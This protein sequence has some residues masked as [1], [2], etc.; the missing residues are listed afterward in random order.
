MLGIS[1][2]NIELTSRCNKKCPMCGRRQL[3]KQ[4]PEYEQ[5]LGDMDFDLFQHIAAQIPA[6]TVVQLH[7][8]GEPTLYEKLYNATLFLR[9]R[10][11]YVCMDTNG[12]LIGELCRELVWFHSITVSVIQG[13]T[14]ENYDRQIHQLALCVASIFLND[15][16]TKIN[17]RA[18]GTIPIYFHT[19]AKRHGIDIIQRIFHAPEMSHSY[20]KKVTMPEIGVCLDLL[21]HPAIDRFGDV[22]PCVRFNPDNINNLGN[23]KN[24]R[25]VDILRD[26][27]RA[28]MIR[29]HFNG[30]RDE[31]PLCDQC[32][33][34]GVP[35]S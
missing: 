14:T 26:P 6:G 5:T 28:E 7:W 18:L 30:K 33:Y 2:I 24:R 11:A 23:V 8:N 20:T 4:D 9:K 21:H 16:E 34:Y 35:T 27:K 10:R 19:F 22:Y 1:T 15:V 31:W 13:D 3:E 25:L 29:I 12:L 32:D 17:I